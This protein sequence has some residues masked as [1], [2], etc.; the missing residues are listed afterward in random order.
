MSAEMDKAIARLKWDIAHA[1]DFKTH[2]PLL[3][4]EERAPSAQ[5]TGPQDGLHAVKNILSVWRH[6]HGNWHWWPW[7]DSK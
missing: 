5:R 7:D 1:F 2:N 4:G 6:E 3:Q